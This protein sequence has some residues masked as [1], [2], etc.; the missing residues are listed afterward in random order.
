M[1]RA[2]ASVAKSAPP[3]LASWHPT[4]PI[5]TLAGHGILAERMAP[6]MPPPASASLSYPVLQLTFKRRGRLPSSRH[7]RSSVRAKAARV[8]S[9]WRRSLVGGKESSAAKVRGGP[10]S[11]TLPYSPRAS[12]RTAAASAVPTAEASFAPSNSNTCPT[13]TSCGAVPL[14]N[15]DATASANARPLLPWKPGTFTMRRERS[16][17]ASS[18]SAT[19]AK[20]LP[21]SPP[22]LAAA[23]SMRAI[24]LPRPTPAVKGSPSSAATALRISAATA[25]PRRKSPLR[26]ITSPPPQTTAAVSAACSSSPASRAPATCA[27]TST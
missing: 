12:L 14:P 21:I 18:S 4:G 6:A 8:S 16:R 24:S 26:R 11:T 20:P 17:R 19:A 23:E 2:A 3:S 9:C 10:R 27:V 15:A 7:R 1:V 25:Q 13:V 5:R 22:G